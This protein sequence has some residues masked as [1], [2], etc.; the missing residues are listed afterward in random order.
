[1]ESASKKG[2]DGIAAIANPKSKGSSLHVIRQS[3][4]WSSAWTA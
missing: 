2:N 3:I 1:M 4:L